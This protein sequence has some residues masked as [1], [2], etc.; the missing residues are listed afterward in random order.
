MLEGT[1]RRS[2]A[3]AFSHMRTILPRD[4]LMQRLL[5][6]VKIQP[7]RQAY[8][9]CMSHNSLAQPY[10]FRVFA[11][12]CPRSTRPLLHLGSFLRLGLL[13]LKGSNH[14]DFTSPSARSTPRRRLQSEPSGSSCSATRC[15]LGAWEAPRLVG[16]GWF[17][18]CFLGNIG[19][20][21]VFTPKTIEGGCSLETIPVQ[22][23]VLEF[24][25][26]KA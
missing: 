21:T 1:L 11:L 8:A 14:T 17:K 9:T 4:M 2:Y 20:T 5:K 6:H 23:E 26:T 10:A 12:F 7:Y 15:A 13:G 16:S 19:K 3:S 25:R 22:Q 18:R 24:R